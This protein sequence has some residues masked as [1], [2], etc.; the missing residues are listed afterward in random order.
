MQFTSHDLHWLAMKTD[1]GCRRFNREKYFSCFFC[2][3]GHMVGFLP[4]ERTRTCHAPSQRNGP[5]RAH[6]AHQVPTSAPRAHQ[7]PQRKLRAPG[8]NERTTRTRSHNAKRD[9]T[10]AIGPNEL[11]TSAPGPNERIR[12][13][14]FGARCGQIRKRGKPNTP[15]GVSYRIK[16]GGQLDHVFPVR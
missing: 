12:K 14:V 9:L 4:N 1:A 8:P 16:L 13:G 6:H 11:T 5:Q 10:R 7:V 2:R 3:F 15:A